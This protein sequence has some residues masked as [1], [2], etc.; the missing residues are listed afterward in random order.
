MQSTQIDSKLLCDKIV[1]VDSSK[2]LGEDKAKLISLGFTKSEIDYVIIIRGLTSNNKIAF[3]TKLNGEL[4]SFQKNAQSYKSKTNQV[5][6]LKHND[7]IF[8]CDDQIHSIQTSLIEIERKE[9]IDKKLKERGSL[10]KKKEERKFQAKME[11]LYES[12]SPEFK[13]WV[14]NAN[15][16][17]GRTSCICI[18]HDA[19]LIAETLRNEDNIDIWFSSDLTNDEL[20]SRLVGGHSGHSMSMVIQLAKRLVTTH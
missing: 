10:M 6:V 19:R 5:V 12:L 1:V 13:E 9:F 20:V 8:I 4:T 18:A 7:H 16:I 3:C 2:K 14:D 17:Y 11:S 15:G